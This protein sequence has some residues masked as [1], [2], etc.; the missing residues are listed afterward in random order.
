MHWLV[1]QF[2]SVR[3]S[4]VRCP[5]CSCCP[6]IIISSRWKYRRGNCY[7]EILL[8][9]SSL[10][11]SQVS[12]VTVLAVWLH[13]NSAPPGQS[14][15][16]VCLHRKLACIE[17]ISSSCVKWKEL[18]GLFPRHSILNSLLLTLNSMLASLSANGFLIYWKRT[19][20]GC[21][22]VM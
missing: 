17:L 15:V 12:Q 10:W 13:P 7:A 20:C 6:I 5:F 21:A 1:L 9:F 3:F 11:V 14:S 8:L 16:N 19:V 18:R 22:I 4:L 2:C